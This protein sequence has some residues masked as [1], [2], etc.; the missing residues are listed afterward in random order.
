M[1][2]L[3]VFSILLTG[4]V[5]RMASAVEPPADVSLK[6]KVKM[7]TLIVVGR[8]TRLTIFNTKT[9]KVAKGKVDVGPGQQADAEI[10]VARILYSAPCEAIRPGTQPESVNVVF[11]QPGWKLMEP[12]GTDEIFFL[13]RNAIPGTTMDYYPFYN[14]TNLS[15]PITEAAGVTH[16]IAAFDSAK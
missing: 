7:A 4:T 13:T 6:D 10:K 14:W 5:L 16:I 9:L 8:V 15:V 11:G 12:T 1:K 3:I 2:S